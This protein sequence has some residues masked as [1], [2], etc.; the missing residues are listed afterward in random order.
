M[1]RRNLVRVLSVVLVALIAAGAWMLWPR[2]ITP[3]PTQENFDRVLVGMSRSEV[4]ALLGTDCQDLSPAPVLHWTKARF[5]VGFDAAGIVSWKQH[6]E[7]R[8][9]KEPPLTSDPGGWLKRQWRK[10]FP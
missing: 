6:A 8:I 1:S 9:I 4:V 10:W 2:P 3:G 5:T 7:G